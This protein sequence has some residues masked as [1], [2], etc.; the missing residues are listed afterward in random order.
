MPQVLFNC[1]SLLSTT[2]MNSI[3]ICY[4]TVVTSKLALGLWLQILN[5]SV[6]ISPRSCTCIFTGV[7]SDVHNTVCLYP[8]WFDIL[9]SA[10]FRHKRWSFLYPLHGV[11]VLDMLVEAAVSGQVVFRLLC[12]RV[13]VI[14]CIWIK[15][16]FIYSE[17][18]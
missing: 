12:V 1:S 4:L 2:V 8:F 3:T 6:Y 13:A 16:Y 17:T 18:V 10:M 9:T 15:S 5:V 11:P 7:V 14:E